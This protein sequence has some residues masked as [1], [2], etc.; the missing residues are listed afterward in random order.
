MVARR[1][2]VPL[3]ILGCILLSLIFRVV[4]PF[5]NVFTPDGIVLNTPDAYYIIRYAETYP[6]IPQYDYFIDYP[7]GAGIGWSLFALVI[8]FLA[9]IFNTNPIF[10][11]AI[12]PP[13][14]FVLTL[15][16]VYFITQTLFKNQY[17]SL[18]SVFILSLLSGNILNR[19]MLGAC[20]THC[21]EL[22]LLTTTMLFFILAVECF[23]K[24][25]CWLYYL[26]FA[27]FMS[28]YWKAWAG[29]LLVP[30][31]LIIPLYIHYLVI[32]KKLLWKILIPIIFLLLCF[33]AYCLFNDKFMYMWLMLKDLFVI[34][35]DKVITEEFSL[36]F[37]AGKFDFSTIWNYY[38][39]TF[40]IMLIGIGWLIYRY[41]KH[42]QAIDLM[43]I[44]WSLVIFTMT[45]VK[46]RFDYYFAVNLSIIV[47]YV[48]V[49]LLVF[50][51]DKK[52]SIVT[53]LIIICILMGMQLFKA[54]IQMATSKQGYMPVEWQETT[55]YLRQ[56]G[57]ND[58]YLDGSKIE[59][60]VFSW[61]DYG[62]WII[63]GSRLPAF[64][65]PG[66]IDDGQAAKIL[67]ETNIDEAIRKLKELHLSYIVID[68]DM[69]MDKLIPILR[70]ANA[71]FSTNMFMFQL[72]YDDVEYIDLIFESSN[73]Q[74]KVFK[75]ND[76]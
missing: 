21:F 76:C 6:D 43:F 67:T 27:V 33:G 70:T 58:A 61:W 24:K 37:T 34:N 5:N 55:R 73:G 12:L 72:F 13:I 30:F 60:G 10:I 18:T 75:L 4:I 71:N 40:Y 65:T 49:R 45:I 29:A 47:A 48:I 42:R 38:G 2:I 26:L 9:K 11:G 46:R 59:Y 22:F 39:L 64:R 66:T 57:D 54:D 50:I 36:L 7:S 17:I 23:D 56:Y 35:L 41:I 15:I 62:Y 44:V 31:I 63:Q 8:G 51:R 3:I 74:V 19:T 32:G 68:R 53:M 52:K 25:M 69:F 20:D 28:M 16:A 1:W 14:L